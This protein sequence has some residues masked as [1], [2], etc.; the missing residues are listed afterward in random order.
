MRVLVVPPDPQQPGLVYPANAGFMLDVD[1]RCRSRSAASCS[2]TC[3]RRARASASTTA[4][5]STPRASARES[6]DERFRI[7]GEADFFP[8]GDVHLLTHGSLERQRFVPALAFPPWKRVYGFRT[9]VRA[10]PLLAALVAP[11][12]VRP[13]RARARGALPRRH[14]AVRLRPAAASS[15]SPTAPASRPRAGRACCDLFGNAV[16]E[17]RDADAARYAANSFSLRAAAASPSW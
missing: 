8:A 14:R 15:C 2:R 9:D 7:E 13:A 1:A 16:I 17:L 4:A 11:R 6:F 3:C 5:C 10:E 12:R